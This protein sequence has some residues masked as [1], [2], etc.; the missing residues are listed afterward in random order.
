MERSK[1]QLT[2]DVRVMGVDALLGAFAT[3]SKK[4]W[5]ERNGGENL[6]HELITAELK[7]RMAPAAGPLPHDREYLVIR[8]P[9]WAGGPYVDFDDVEGGIRWLR[10]NYS[11][12]NGATNVPIF[13]TL[14]NV[15]VALRR[16][17]EGL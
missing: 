5:W 16:E 10:G 3:V 2:E 1:E 14:E 9:K 4:P 12:V 7:R 11:L 6:V 8:R 13:Q 17:S 15:C